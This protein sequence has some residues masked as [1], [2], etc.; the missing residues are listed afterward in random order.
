MILALILGASIVPI[1]L[2]PTQVQAKFKSTVG[3]FGNGEEAGVA[4]GAD[5]F[6]AGGP[7]DSTCPS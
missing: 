7:N 5:A 4:A 3:E 6:R 2:V 1:I